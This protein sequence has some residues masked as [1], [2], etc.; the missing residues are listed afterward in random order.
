MFEPRW[1]RN[2]M[3][4]E[5]ESF[6][7]SFRETDLWIGVNSAAFTAS[8]RQDCRIIAQDL[9]SDLDNYLRGDPGYQHALTP[10]S[11]RLTCPPVAAAM[12]LAAQK[13]NVG[14]MAAVA[15]AFAQ[16]I[17]TRLEQKH[18]ITDIIIENGGDI[19]L[20]TTKPRRISIWAG[21]SVLS[22]KLSIEIMPELSP[23]GICTSS[24]TV[25]HSLSFGQADA[26]TILAKNAAVADA[27]ATAVGNMIKTFQDIKPALEYSATQPEITGVVIIAGDRL[28]VRGNV[29]LVKTEN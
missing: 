27:Y 9:Y 14:P 13:A 10:Y 8:L 21:A 5:L 29:K 7:V 26:V 24:G 4:S 11:P 22:N 17:S 2:Q 20:R 25:G 3:R 1:Y 23:L 18:P 6:T 16:E 19:Y 12:A 28:G 15:G